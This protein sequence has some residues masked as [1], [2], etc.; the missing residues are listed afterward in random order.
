VKSYREKWASS[1]MMVDS[2]VL[3]DLGKLDRV[4][5][6]SRQMLDCLKRLDLWNVNRDVRQHYD[7]LQSKVKKAERNG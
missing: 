7:E 6:A 3:R 5:A 2:T 4:L 1:Q